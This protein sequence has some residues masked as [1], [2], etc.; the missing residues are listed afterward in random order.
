MPV[1]AYLDESQRSRYL[2]CATLVDSADLSTVRALAQSLRMPGQHRWHF[3]SE[4]DRRR[5]TILSALASC[6]R[7]RGLVYTSRAPET[8]ARAG[9]LTALVPDLIEHGVSQLTLESRAGRDDEDRPVLYE[10]LRKAGAGM[11]YQ[12][13]RPVAEPALWWPDAVAWAYGAGGDWRRRI[14]PIVA[15][16]RHL[17]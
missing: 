12:H 17:P 9:C 1:M 14:A 16:I 10:A 13:R 8:L 3:K 7:V 2:V 15:R 5:K 11:P 4:S 6:G